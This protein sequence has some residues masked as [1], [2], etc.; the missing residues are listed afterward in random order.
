MYGFGE[1]FHTSQG[2]PYS[3]VTACEPLYFLNTLSFSFFA[4]FVFFV[5]KILIRSITERIYIVIPGST[6]YHP[7]PAFHLSRC[8]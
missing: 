2:K 7:P 4:A 6:T 5:E 8:P 1:P 3:A